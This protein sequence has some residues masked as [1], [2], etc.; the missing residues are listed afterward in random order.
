VHFHVWIILG[1]SNTNLVTAVVHAEVH[2]IPMVFISVGDPV[3]SGFV[4][5][6]AALSSLFAARL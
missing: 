4:S 3:G 2:T 1:A 5:M 6:T